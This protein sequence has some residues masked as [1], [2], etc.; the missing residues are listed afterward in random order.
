MRI[1]TSFQDAS[2]EEVHRNDPDHVFR[3][4]LPASETGVRRGL[5]SISKSLKKV[6]FKDVDIQDVELALAEVLNNV[7]EHAYAGKKEGEIEINLFVTSVGLFASIIDDGHPMPNS[8]L[9][10][11]HCVDPNTPTSELPEGGFGWFLIRQLTEDLEYCR[12][13][14]QNRLDF[15]MLVGLKKK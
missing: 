13:G 8:Q 5:I 15:R 9:P 14:D 1:E 7:V 10:I 6:D 12:I 3:L 2:P 11:G 4:V